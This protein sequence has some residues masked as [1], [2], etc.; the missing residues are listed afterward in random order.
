MLEGLLRLAADPFH[1]LWL[2]ALVAAARHEGT[3]R[4]VEAWTS[5]S[6]LHPTQG[7]FQILLKDLP[8]FQRK[9]KE[10]EKQGGKGLPNWAK[11]AY[12]EGNLPVRVQATKT[13]G[14]PL[15]IKHSAS[16]RAALYGTLATIRFMYPYWT[17]AF[18][19][20]KVPEGFFGEGSNAASVVPNHCVV[21]YR[22]LSSENRARL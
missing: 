13:E 22:Y 7:V 6:D 18:G 1:T 10:V 4:V 16:V 17:F 5:L 9:C 11:E 2:C 12:T 20:H 8:I 14:K 19:S 3:K 15:V 21:A